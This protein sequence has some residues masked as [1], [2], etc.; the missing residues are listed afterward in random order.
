MTYLYEFLCA[1]HSDLTSHLIHDLPSV[2][3]SRWRRR[4]TA[5][6]AAKSRVGG[7]ASSISVT[8]VVIVWGA[9]HVVIWHK[10]VVI[11]LPRPH[12]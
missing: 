8:V 10:G 5:I 6:A 3:S 1:R 9:V 2:L 11:D 4:A 7:H 12:L